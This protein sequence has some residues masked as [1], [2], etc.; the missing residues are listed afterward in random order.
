MNRYIQDAGYELDSAL[1]INDETFNL[2]NRL[3]TFNANKTADSK[4]KLWGFDYQSIHSPTQN[5]AIDI[6]DFVTN[7]NQEHKIP[8]IDQFSL[9]LMQEDRSLAINFLDTHRAEIGKLLTTE[10]IECLLHIMKVSKEMGDDGIERFRQRDHVMFLNAS[11]LIENF[12]KTEGTK[13]I[14]YGHA[15]HINPV[16]TYP[17]VPCTPFGQYMHEVYAEDY[18]PLLLLSG[19]GKSVAYDKNYN[20]KNRSLNPTPP[21][22]IEHAL[23]TIDD[24]LLYLPLTND[25]DKLTLSRFK[26][27]HHIAQEFYPFNLYQRYKGLFF[28]KNTACE[29]LNEEEMSFEKSFEIFLLK[30]KQRQK[31]L[32]EI[33]KRSKNYH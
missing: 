17:A 12:A 8:E 9:L 1:V 28:I 6:F 22:S 4:V 24:D 27:S 21:N 33:Q 23:S 32:E 26:G 5:S 11:F 2:L 29:N 3:R 16:S 14:I 31:E 18:S 30:T 13:T 25:F 20:R 15:A 19:K 7:L 10:E